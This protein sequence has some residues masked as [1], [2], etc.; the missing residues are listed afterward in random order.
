MSRLLADFITCQELWA[1]SWTG[2]L[3]PDLGLELVCKL[4]ILKAMVP[5]TFFIGVWGENA[6]YVSRAFFHQALKTIK[7]RCYSPEKVPLI[8]RK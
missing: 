8:Y 6:G 7:I 3:E 2:K 4:Y 1:D 5:E